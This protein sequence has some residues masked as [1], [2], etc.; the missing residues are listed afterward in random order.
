LPYGRRNDAFFN[1][2]WSLVNSPKMIEEID[3]RFHSEPPEEFR[4]SRLFDAFL[5]NQFRTPMIAGIGSLPSC[6]K[7]MGKGAG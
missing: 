4:K 7:M 3:K 1:S 2:G 5:I 6:T